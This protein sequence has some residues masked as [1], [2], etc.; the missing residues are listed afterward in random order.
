MVQRNTALA[1][2]K[3]EFLTRD[4]GR[5]VIE[6]SGVN[7]YRCYH[8]EM[9]TNGCPFL[10]T[11]DRAPNVIIRLLQFGL[12]EEVLTSSTIWVCVGCYTCA[13]RCPMGIDIPT[14]M[15]TLR[16]IVLE[17][18]LPV[19]EPDVLEFHRQVVSSIKRHGRAH[20]LEIMVGY[21]FKKR[22]WLSDWLLGIKMLAKHKLDLTPSRVKRIEEVRALFEDHEE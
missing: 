4:L 1:L 8:C 17:K 11:M 12:F 7:F 13:Y 20:K 16:E 15:D 6:R 10:P 19:A 22:E 9:C 2:I 21:K 5:L 18:G 3:E 14:L